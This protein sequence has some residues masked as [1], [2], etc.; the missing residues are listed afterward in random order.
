MGALVGEISLTLSAIRAS[1][2]VTTMVPWNVQIA[3]SL[4]SA[5]SLLQVSQ[6]LQSAILFMRMIGLQL[7]YVMTCPKRQHW[8]RAVN[9]LSV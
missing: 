5:N 1:C 8:L 2:L 3:I 9:K 6:K 4:A 7:N